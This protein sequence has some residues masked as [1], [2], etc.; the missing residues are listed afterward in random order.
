M[1]TNRLCIDVDCFKIALEAHLNCFLEIKYSFVF[2]PNY[3]LTEPPHKDINGYWNVLS[4]ILFSHLAALFTSIAHPQ[5]LKLSLAT[6]FPKS[7]AD[8]CMTEEDNRGPRTDRLWWF[9]RPSS[10]TDD[11]DSLWLLNWRSLVGKG[12][13][14]C[15]GDWA[16]KQKER[17]QGPSE[18]ENERER[19]VVRYRTAIL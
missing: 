12:R 10:T 3:S 5:T 2:S 19:K 9:D 16:R 6:L 18:R 1:S 11:D 15:I 13:R 7:D 4:A 8:I 14:M 17:S